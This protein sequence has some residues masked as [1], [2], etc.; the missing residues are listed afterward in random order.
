MLRTTAILTAAV[1]IANTYAY[2][3]NY[4]TIKNESQFPAELWIWPQSLGKY[5]RPETFLRPRS[6]VSIRYRDGEKYWLVG[7]DEGREFPLGWVDIGAEMKREKRPIVIKP[8][9]ETKTRN[10]EW[11]DCRTREKKVR[12]QT[13]TVHRLLWDGIEGEFPPGFWERFWEKEGH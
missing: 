1:A 8:V 11:W 13:Y 4:V 12:V 5:R 6:S 2:A 10:H 7:R 9:F 3:D